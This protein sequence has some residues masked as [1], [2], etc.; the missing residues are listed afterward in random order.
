[1][2]SVNQGYKIG[3]TFFI[4]LWPLLEPKVK[5]LDVDESDTLIMHELFFYEVCSGF[6][7]SAEWIEA[8][9]RVKYVPREQQ[10]QLGLT[11]TELFSCALEFCKLHNE[12]WKNILDYTVRHLESIQRHPEQHPLEWDIWKKT[13]EH[14][15]MYPGSFYDVDWSVELS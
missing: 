15:G 14:I 11:E 1:M 3:L 10:K 13:R 9:S 6:E 2:L 8:V 12:R 4:D 5:E 7:S